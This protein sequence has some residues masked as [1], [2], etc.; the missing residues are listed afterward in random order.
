[1]P[2][3]KGLQSL[4]KGLQNLLALPISLRQLRLARSRQALC[5]VEFVQQ[6][7]DCGGDIDAAKI[8]WREL[9]DWT[10]VDGFTAYPGDSLGSVFGMAEEELDE[11]LVLGI[12]NELNIAIPSQEF[13]SAFGVVDTPLQVATFVARCR[14]LGSEGKGAP[15][16]E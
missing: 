16:R 7:A 14:Q 10:C 12:L 9:K 15:N 4:L 5:E 1:M 13:V 3:S 11:D 6:I 2:S 8:L